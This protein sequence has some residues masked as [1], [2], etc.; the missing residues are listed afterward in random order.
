MKSSAKL[1]L[2]QLY[3]QSIYNFPISIRESIR[4]NSIKAEMRLIVEIVFRGFARIEKLGEQNLSENKELVEI[5]NK[6]TKWLRQ[7]I[8]ENAFIS[9]EKICLMNR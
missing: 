5:I 7:I 8:F 9:E 3:A 6:K 2:Y 1:Y 4:K